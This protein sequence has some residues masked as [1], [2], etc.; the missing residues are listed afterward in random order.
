MTTPKPHD[1]RRPHTSPEEVEEQL[2]RVL[3]EPAE[4]ADAEVA[5]LEAAHDVL[6]QALQNN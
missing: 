3:G 6:H 1:P 4:D 5:Q 2:N